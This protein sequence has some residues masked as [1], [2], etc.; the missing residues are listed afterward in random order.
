MLLEAST[1]RTNCRRMWANFHLGTKGIARFGLARSEARVPFI[2]RVP[3]PFH[4]PACNPVAAHAKYI[5]SFFAYF[6]QDEYSSLRIDATGLSDAQ[7]ARARTGGRYRTV[8]AYY[9]R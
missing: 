7:N 8:S 9:L 2:T 4:T 6:L 3:F 5:V 1:C